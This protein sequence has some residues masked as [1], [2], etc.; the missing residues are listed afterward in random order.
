MSQPPN[1]PPP[2]NPYDVP[3]RPGMS[4]TG[5]VL[6]GLGIGCG[7]LVVLCCGVVGFGSY[8]IVKVAK[9][10]TSQ[11]PMKVTDLTEEIVR[12]DIP[13]NL[14]P[15]LGLNVNLPFV[16]PVVKGAMYSNSDK[17]NHLIIGQINQSFGDRHNLETQLRTSMSHDEEDLEVSET[18][19]L[20][21]KINGEVAH[22]N[23]SRGVGE[24]SKEEYWEVVGQFKG[25][26][27]PAVLI[28]KARVADMTKDQILEMLKS[29]E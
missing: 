15:V 14:K 16:G 2:V 7:L 23:I 1:V 18:E 5:K 28:L 25:D 26:E 19:T 24:D 4:G 3:Q 20:D 27:G 8:A 6:L 29:M 17:K 21:T 9:E 10:S 13:E 22:F 12:I 11:D